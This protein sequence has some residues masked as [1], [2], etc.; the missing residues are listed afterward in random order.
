[1]QQGFDWGVLVAYRGLLLEGLVATLELVAISLVL[2]LVLG[3]ALGLGRTYAPRPLA[4]LFAAYTEFFRNVPPIVQFFFWYFAVNL[5]VLPA[6]AIGLSV[7]TSAYVGEI[8]RSG[9]QAIPRTQFEA[10]RSSGMT[11]LQQAVWIVLPQ[12]FIRIIPPLS[13]EFINIVKNSAVAMT[14]GYAELTFASQEIEAKT[15]R[16]FEAATAVTLLYIAI[17]FAIVMIMH[18][19]EHFAR[20]NL[21]RG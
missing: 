11:M 5:D 16:G 18:A 15:F 14:I 10:A 8:V 20:L 9:I 12:A 13:I 3:T 4:A 7:F 17:A 19:V 1:M 2:S 21:R 6:A